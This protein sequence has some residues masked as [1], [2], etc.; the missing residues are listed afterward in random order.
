MAFLTEQPLDLT[1]LVARVMSPERGG[2]ACFLGVVRDHH[3]GRS[4]TRLEYSAYDAMAEAECERVVAEAE[5]KWDV[6][7]ALEHRTGRLEIGEVAVVIAAAA[8]H[9]DAAF[10]AC[11]FVIE[12]VKRRVPIWKREYFLDGTSAWVAPRTAPQAVDRSAE[13]APDAPTPEPASHTDWGV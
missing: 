7:V 10:M 13:A 2:V 8:P 1:P 11:R 9:R 4:V 3:D 12:Q 6:R 5:A